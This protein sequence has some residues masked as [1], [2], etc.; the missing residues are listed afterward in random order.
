S[1]DLERCK[2]DTSCF[3]TS[4]LSDEDSKKTLSKYTTEKLKNG[5]CDVIMQAKMLDRFKLHV[6]LQ[7][8]G[9][10][11]KLDHGI[12]VVQQID[13]FHCKREN[14][15]KEI[16]GN[17]VFTLNFLGSNK[18]ESQSIFCSF[19]AEANDKTRAFSGAFF[20]NDKY[21]SIVYAKDT[22]LEAVQYKRKEDIMWRDIHLLDNC[23]HNL[24]SSSDK[25]DLKSEYAWTEVDTTRRK[26]TCPF[27]HSS[28]LLE[29]PPDGTPSAGVSSI[30]CETEHWYYEVGSKKTKIEGN[31]PLSALKSYV[32]SARP[33]SEY[34]VP[35][36]RMRLLQQLRLRMLLRAPVLSVIQAVLRSTVKS[37]LVARRNVPRVLRDSCGMWKER[38]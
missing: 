11:L 36:A 19:T 27:A 32:A 31:S 38:S 26:F 9:Q 37:C 13:Q 34:R 29:I 10:N 6:M 17:S 35:A 8:K 2:D 33:R 3:E 7:A 23:D 28:F 25:A 14:E 18:F 21:P 22:G 5:D 1:I 15:K 24:V 20:A 30:F 12:K 4:N 16:K